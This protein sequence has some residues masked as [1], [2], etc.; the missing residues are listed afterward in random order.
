MRPRTPRGAR[1]RRAGSRS[2]RH[3]GRSRCSSSPRAPTHPGRA[4]RRQRRRRGSFKAPILSPADQH[5]DPPQQ[6]RSAG[7]QQEDHADQDHAVDDPWLAPGAT[8]RRPAPTSRQE[9]D[10]DGSSDQPGKRPE[11][12]DDVRR[13]AGRSRAAP[14]TCPGSRRSLRLRT[15]AGHTGVGRAHAE[16]ERLVLGEA[17]SGGKGGGLAVA[18]RADCPARAEEPRRTT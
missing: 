12:A 16:G 13:R 5:G 4:P 15:G 9:L 7:R 2:A 8:S 18:H 3:P 17:D 10:E 1:C 14:E 11:P 6:P